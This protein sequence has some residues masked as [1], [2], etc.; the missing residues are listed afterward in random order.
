VYEAIVVMV[1]CADSAEAQKI[2]NAVVEERLVACATIAGNVRSFFHWQGALV[3]ETETLLLMKTRPQC[4]DELSKRVKQLHSY[5][6]PEIIALP[7][8]AGSP[9]YIAWLREST[10]SG[11]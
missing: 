6:V 10:V 11:E 3:R 5:Q 7:V 1:T 4:F 8:V 9:E 2:A